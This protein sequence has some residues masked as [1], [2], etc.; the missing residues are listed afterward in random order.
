[1]CC[2]NAASCPDANTLSRIMFSG[3]KQQKNEEKEQE[4]HLEN[5]GTNVAQVCG[6]KTTTSLHEG[7]DPTRC[8][9][10]ASRE[11]SQTCSRLLHAAVQ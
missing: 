11:N 8:F 5:Q 6:V 3:P 9:L 7:G 4:R 10:T 1:M 2:N